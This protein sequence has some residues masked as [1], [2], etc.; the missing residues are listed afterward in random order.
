MMGGIGGIGAAVFGV[1]WIFFALSIGAPP[2]FALFGILF[3]VMAIAGS[4]YNF[5]NATRKNRFSTFD[6]TSGEEESDPLTKAFGHE[7]KDYRKGSTYR[8]REESSPVEP[9]PP[10]SESPRQ[11]EGNYCPFCGEE[12]KPEFDFCPQCGKDI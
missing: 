12:V 11:Y 4:I 3:I 8:R 6:I 2:I 9:A 7:K 5:S 1:F 10:S